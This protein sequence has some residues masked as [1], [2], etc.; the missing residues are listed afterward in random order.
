MRV[1]I[2]VMYNPGKLQNISDYFEKLNNR[3]EKGT[4]FYRINGY[5][6]EI[7]NFIAGYYE[8]ARLAGVVIEGRI[9]NP[10]EKNLA[11]YD[12]IMGSDFRM[13]AGF[14]ENGLKRWLPRME[15]LPRRNVA[16]SI[17]DTLCR[18]QQE[19][20]NENMLK[21]AYIKF[22]CWFYYKFERI[23]NKLGNDDVPKIL[24]EGDISNYEL[25]FLSILA[26]AGCD[27]VLLQRKGD[28]AYLKLD[29]KSE[30]S[31]LFETDGMTEFPE[32]FSIRG[33][34]QELKE[35]MDTERLYG[36]K[37]QISGCTNNW[38]TGAPFD[39]I[40]T[41]TTVRGGEAKMFYNCFYRVNGVE[42]KLTYLNELYQFWLELKNS[43]RKI[44][45]IDEG[46]PQPAPEE[47]S[48]IRRNNYKNREQMLLD[49][50]TNIQYTA[51]I[52]LQRIMNKA[53]VDVLMEESQAAEVNL[54]KLTNKAVYLLCWLKRYQKELF[55]N[56][57]APDISCFIYMGGCSNENEAMFIEFLSRLPIDVLIL[58]PN[59]N[60][61]CCLKSGRLKEI[62]NAETMTADRFPRENSDI[63]MGTAAYHAER[64]LDTIMYQDSG[65]YRNRQYDKAVAVNLQTMCE[66]IPIL[67]NTE[68]KYRA[69]F[70]VVDSVVN[71]PVI[72]A[73]IS[74]VKN[75]NMSKYWSDIK[76]MM[77][78]DTYVIKAVPFIEST[79]PNPVK[80]HV[81]EFFKNG[82]L[83]RDKIM[84]HQCYQYGHLREETQQHI[85]DKLAQLI[86]QKIIKGT[87]ENGTEYTIIS[88]VLNMNKD[89]V[90]LIQKFDFTKKNPKLVYINVTENTISLEDSILTAFLN[91]VGFDIVFFVPT[92][93][94][95]VERYFNKRIME[96][97]QNGEYIYDLTIP[98]FTNVLVTE[99]NKLL[100]RIFRRG[101]N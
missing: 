9:P 28:D 39:D 88:T 96:E 20:K 53:F 26:G 83:N 22:M 19:G 48:T 99:G 68:L 49:L 1:K 91:L 95:S 40:R 27:I 74:G 41:A 5:S 67:W 52:E 73:K 81:T 63:R 72:F 17:Y 10:D 79:A 92:G 90:R 77:G 24:Y 37:P 97:H 8:A 57:N 29:P 87:F 50:S 56:W 66:E 12:E 100:D 44:V 89:I 11:Y 25:K 18:M 71:M 86:E 65:I 42:D 13:D 34:Q 64:E 85:L 61:T 101:R 33:L 47:I 43:G 98:D 62:N 60:K 75:G 78:D 36:I 38:G 31:Y 3:K 93:Y 14:I 58:K 7:R 69:N 21:N 6:G 32:S 84:S 45:V 70:S 30:V 4:Y 46:I 59:L 23:V 2:D 76:K 15:E 80:A 54:N 82:R 35:R 94:Q 51:N 55:T 16:G